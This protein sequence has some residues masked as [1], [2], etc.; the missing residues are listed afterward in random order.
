MRLRS[1][2][3]SARVGESAAGERWAAGRSGSGDGATAEVI[4]VKQ[5]RQPRWRGTLELASAR[6]VQRHPPWYARVGA[7]AVQASR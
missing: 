3:G 7:G 4:E 5:R 2:Q 6:R 1:Q